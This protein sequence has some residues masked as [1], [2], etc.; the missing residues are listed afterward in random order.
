MAD[1]K[2]TPRLKA[3]YRKEIIPALMKKFEYKSIMQVPKITKICLNQGVGTA[4]ADKKQIEAALNEMASISGQKPV[5]TKSKK[6]ISNFKLR[7]GVPI[8]ARVTLRDNNMYEFL[9][10]L[11]AVSLPRIRDFRG[12]NEKGFDG[13]GNYTLG[14]TEQIIFPEID[15]DK[16]SK[17]TGMDI[18]FVTT[19]KTDEEARELLEQFG[20]PFKNRT[21]TENQ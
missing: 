2:Y 14:V 16:V 5:T 6:D 8:G 7:K 12:I 4:V 3:R 15:I 11:I 17:I 10:R 20:L 21:V 13:R 1:N 19:A 18:T 9:D